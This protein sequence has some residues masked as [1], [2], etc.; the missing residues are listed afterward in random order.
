MK[1]IIITI[2]F[3]FFFLPPLFA[4]DSTD[5]EHSP[6]YN[7][8]NGTWV[9]RN[10]FQWTVTRVNDD[11]SLTIPT[12]A[13]IYDCGERLGVLKE[14]MNN[15]NAAVRCSNSSKHGEEYYVESIQIICE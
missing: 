10:E 1:N 11:M 4:Q 13:V 6:D 5:E 14:H 7:P 9:I 12:S 3:L 2:L 8:C 15:A